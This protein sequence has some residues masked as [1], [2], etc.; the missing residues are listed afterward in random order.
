M[1]KKISMFACLSSGWPESRCE[2]NDIVADVDEHQTPRASFSKDILLSLLR[3]RR[4]LSIN[5]L[6]FDD[7]MALVLV[8]ALQQCRSVL[9]LVFFEIGAM[10]VMGLQAFANLKSM[11]SLRLSFDQWDQEQLN[12]SVFPVFAHFT[13]LQRLTIDYAQMDCKFDGLVPF[14]SSTSLI[15]LAL[16]RLKSNDSLRSLARFRSLTSLSLNQCRFSSATWQFFAKRCHSLCHLLFHNCVSLEPSALKALLSIPSLVSLACLPM[17]EAT[18]NDALIQLRQSSLTSLHV[19]PSSTSEL[20]VLC[21]GHGLTDLISLTLSSNL[22]LVIDVTP[23][24]QIV[25]LET[26]ALH[27]MRLDSSELMVICRKM[28]NLTRLDISTCEVKLNAEIARCVC[29]MPCLQSFLANEFK[30]KTVSNVWR[31][32]ASSTLTELGLFG[33]LSS[34]VDVLLPFAHNTSLLSLSVTPVYKSLP[35]SDMN[36]RVLTAFL[37]HNHTLLSFHFDYLDLQD[38]SVH[39]PFMRHI[40]ANRCRFL[41]WKRVVFLLAFMRANRT[42]AFVESGRVL[43]S[44]VLLFEANNVRSAWNEYNASKGETEL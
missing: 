6:G 25:H 1:L 27:C 30:T 34:A 22:F 40:N 12:A 11:T 44:E 35:E 31:L 14:L 5:G 7:S 32:F 17:D 13:H 15:S 10:T 20:Q 16:V 42:H 9:K 21:D 4:T 33:R 19:A 38:E 8:D 23:A 36:T 24:T 29:D 39:R 2:P 43:V 41:N 28:V 37:L 3:G 26:L 18:C